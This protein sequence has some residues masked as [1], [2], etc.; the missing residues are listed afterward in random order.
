MRVII[1]PYGLLLGSSVFNPQ[2]IESRG[3]PYTY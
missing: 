2:R 3:F 1:L